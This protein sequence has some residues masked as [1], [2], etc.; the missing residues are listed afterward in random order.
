MK[1][2]ALLVVLV[3]ACGE[4]KE[5]DG[6]GDNQPPTDVELSASSVEEQAPPGTRVG[7]LSG[8]DPDAGDHHSFELTAD[9][10]GQFALDGAAVVVAPDAILD[11]ETSATVTIGVRATDDAGDSVDADLDIEIVDLR[12]VVNTDD[13]GAGSLRQAIEDADPGE[14]I[15]FETGVEGSISV[16]SVLLLTK[17]V[18]IRGP[19]PPNQITLDALSGNGV[20]E[21]SPAISVTLQQLTIRGG[22]AGSGGGVSNQ[23][24]LI[25]ERC[26]F[27]DN[28]AAGFGRGG[29]IENAGTLT[30]RDCLFRRNS[31][32][33]GGAVAADSQ[34][35]SSFERCTFQEN[36]AAGNSGGAI[37]GGSVKILNSTFVGNTASDPDLDRVGGAVALFD[38]ANLIAFSTFT[39]NFADGNGGAIFCTLSEGDSSTLGLRGSIVSGNDAGLGGADLSIDSSCIL[40]GEHDVVSVGSGSGLTDGVD[41]NVV[42]TAVALVELG[43]NGGPTPTALPAADS[44][45]VDLVPAESCTNLEGD[46]LDE[47]QRGEPRPAGDACDAGAVEL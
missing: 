23:G 36:T 45:S 3:A 28:V 14:T 26:I 24:A 17:N 5:D 32:Y 41:G 35:G 44:V 43:D 4:V 10:D 9:G 46:A 42:G 7:L 20:F 38:G 19:R 16:S 12:E 22:S 37:V 47:D 2:L 39:G 25:A 1:R 13:T 18:T 40:T 8:V 29:A 34:A 15:L 27:E 31:G 30:A 21:I 33:N 6:G 11:H